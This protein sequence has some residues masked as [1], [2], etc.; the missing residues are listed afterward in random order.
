MYD[1]EVY[2]VSL[3]MLV[4]EIC[5]EPAKNLKILAS[6]CRSEAELATRLRQ[7]LF[8]FFLTLGAISITNII[9]IRNE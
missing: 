1:W 6:R 2:F 9:K 7:K 4:V 5:D 8:K 3:I